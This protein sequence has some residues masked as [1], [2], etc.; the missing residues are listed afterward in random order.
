MKDIGIVQGSAAQAV[1]LV[2]GVDTVYVHTDITHLP[3]D[4]DGNDR[5]FGYHEIQY[6]KD[7]YIKIIGE[8]N[9]SVEQQ[10]TDTQL[11]LVEVYELVWGGTVM[12][13]VYA[14]LIRK[15]LKILEEV[16]DKLKAAVKAILDGDD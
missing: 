5:G 16:P 4:E 10:L 12:A 9:A 1:P 2:V 8:T 6:D 13:R 15:G 7:E 3:P 14:D 11:A